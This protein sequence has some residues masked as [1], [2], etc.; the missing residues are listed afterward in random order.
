MFGYDLG[1]DLGTN[2]VVITVPGKGVVINEPSYVAFD[3]ETEK[4]LYAGRRAYYLQ[5]REP[6]GITVIQPLKNGVIGSY[7][8][9]QQMVKYFIARAIKKSIFKPRVVASIPPL[10]TDVDRRTLVSVIVSAGARSVCLVEEPLCAAFGAGIDPLQPNGAFVINIGGGT[11]DMAVVSQGAL[12]QCETVNIAGNTFDE[13]IMKYVREKYDVL[14][15]VR[16]AEDIKKQIGC[17]VQRKEEIVMAAKG[18]SAKDG[19]PK[20][21]EITSNE[22]YHCLKPLLGEIVAAAQVMF[23][24]T[25]PQLVADIVNSGIILTGGSAELYALDELFKTEME[26]DVTVAAQP[27]LC[28]AKGAGVALDKMKILDS[29][30]YRFQTKEEVRI[31]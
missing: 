1:I 24:R 3:T 26:L 30:G 28:V 23:A 13:E 18:R 10:A 9:A 12:S 16:T 21:I 15:G 7:A 19:M 22:V 11:T 8:M 29:Y 25:S 4:M 17:A 27:N 5:G 20:A 14:I 6:N 2:N 31:R